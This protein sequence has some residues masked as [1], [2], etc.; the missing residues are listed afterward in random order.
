MDTKKWVATLHKPELPRKRGRLAI[1]S[2]PVVADTWFNAR[3]IATRI[4]TQKLYR[5][6]AREEFSVLPSD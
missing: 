3:E 2:V 5:P 4:F 6:V 1:V